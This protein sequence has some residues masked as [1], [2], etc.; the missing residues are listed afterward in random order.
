MRITDGTDLG[1]YLDYLFGRNDAEETR[2]LCKESPEKEGEKGG[3]GDM[4][5]ID[6][7]KEKEGGRVD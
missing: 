4:R 5:K 3:M 7:N 6:R 2:G 1:D